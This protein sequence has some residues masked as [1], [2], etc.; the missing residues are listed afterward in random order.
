MADAW[1]GAFGDAFGDAFGAVVSPGVQDWDAWGGSFNAAFG[2]SFG[3]TT[4]QPEQ[5]DEPDAVTPGAI[6]TQRWQRS[7][8]QPTPYSEVPDWSLVQRRLEASIARDRA[9]KMKNQ[10]VLMLLMAA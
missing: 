3:P 7:Q 4:A 6:G 10:Q 9:Q 1:S 2:G 8:K 5:Q